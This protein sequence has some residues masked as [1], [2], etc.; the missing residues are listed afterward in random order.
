ML[1]F[2]AT[3]LNG[4]QIEPQEIIEFPVLMVD[5]ENFTVVDQF[6]QYV[7]GRRLHCFIGLPKFPLHLQLMSQSLIIW[8][9]PTDEQLYSASRSVQSAGIL[10]RAHW[11]HPGHGGRPA[12][13]ARDPGDVCLLVQPQRSHPG[14][15][16]LRHLRPLGPQDDA[17]PSV[18]ILGSAHS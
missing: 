7:K 15:L 5:S 9:Q 8:S 2:E 13:L 11:D 1:D 17:A 12:D 14:Q 3:C 4:V 16:H 6:H 18:S 10:H